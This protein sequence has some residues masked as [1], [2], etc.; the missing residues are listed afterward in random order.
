MFFQAFYNVST[1][2]ICFLTNVDNYNQHFLGC[3]ASYH[4]G[5]YCQSLTLS[6][7]MSIIWLASASYQS[8]SVH[9]N[10]RGFCHYLWDLWYK[11]KTWKFFQQA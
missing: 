2:E 6:R 1:D 8:K 7:P 11:Y 10:L 5:W 9:V 3:P 4:I